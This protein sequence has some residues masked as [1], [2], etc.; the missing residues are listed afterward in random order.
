MILLGPTKFIILFPI[1]IQTITPTLIL[2]FV[3]TSSY[4]VVTGPWVGDTLGLYP[5]QNIQMP[6]LQPVVPYILMT[7]HPQN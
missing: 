6:L 3:T 2:L 4:F 7:M 5:T 1:F